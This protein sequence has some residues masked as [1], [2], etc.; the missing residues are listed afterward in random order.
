LAE[1]APTAAILLAV[2]LVSDAQNSSSGG[3][4]LT[5]VSEF[6]VM[7][8]GP[9]S[10]AT[11]IKVTPVVSLRNSVRKSWVVPPF[12]PRLSLYWSVW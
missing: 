2:A 6:T 10:P 7:P 12:M 3:S 8:M 9:A 5:G 11:A 4:R 1:K